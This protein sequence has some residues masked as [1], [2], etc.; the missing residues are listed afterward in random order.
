MD[1]IHISL[2]GIAVV[3][4]I[5]RRSPE[6]HNEGAVDRS[7]R[8]DRGRSSEGFA[9]IDVLF[10]VA[11]IGILSG[12]AVPSLLRGRVAANEAAAIASMRSTHTAQM[13][14]MLTCGRGFYASSYSGLGDGP[15]GPGFLPLD[16]TSSVAP[17]KSGYV[18]TLAA[19][20]GGVAGPADCNGAATTSITY[21]ATAIPLTPETTGVRAFAINQDGVIWQDMSGVAPVEPFTIGPGVAPVQ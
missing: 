18:L 21:Y 12:I 14:Y 19:G 2:T 13:G 7:Q 4:D 5:R 20:A 11:I 10:V 1:D 6:E 9:L 8:T 16:L 3:F 17:S 15:G